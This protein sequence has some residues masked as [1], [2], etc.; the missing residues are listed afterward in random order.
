[1]EEKFEDLKEIVILSLHEEEDLYVMIKVKILSIK[2]TRTRIVRAKINNEEF[3]QTS[4]PEDFKL[5]G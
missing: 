2:S 1:M 5:T 3:N 4:N